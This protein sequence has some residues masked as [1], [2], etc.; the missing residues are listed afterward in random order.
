MSEI[1]VISLVLSGLSFIVAFVALIVSIW[2]SKEQNKISSSMPL[3]VDM[4]KEFRSKEFKKSA[5]YILTELESA[6]KPEKG[7]HELDNEP[8]SHIETVSHFFN[9]IGLLVEK[10]LVDEDLVI[11]YLGGSAEEHWVILEP[12][13]KKQRDLNK[14]PNY[15]RQFEWLINKIRSKKQ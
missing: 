9:N 14:K 6:T 15:Q 1:E 10:N 3:V 5:E 8:K 11:D 2:L 12:Y 13:I 7:V 4:F